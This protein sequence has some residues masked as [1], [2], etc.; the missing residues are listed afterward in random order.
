ML[1]SGYLHDAFLK[2]RN[3]KIF[4]PVSARLF[5]LSLR[6]GS[7]SCRFLLAVLLAKS[8]T[9][10]EFGLYSLIAAAVVY[11]VYVV[12][13]DFYT[14]N[15]R[16]LIGRPVSTWRALLRDQCLLYGLTFTIVAC[17]VFLFCFRG[18]IAWETA[19]WL[20][21]LLA[22]EHFAQELNRLLIISG[23][24]LQSSIELFIRS[25]I[26]VLALF[27]DL[28][29]ESA[30]SLRLSQV[31]TLWLIGC[32]FAIA[33]SL[34][35]LRPVLCDRSSAG[36][37]INWYR[38]R[39][40][41]MVS[42]VFLCSTLVLKGA[43]TVDRFLVEYF[44]GLAAVGA[45][46]FYGSLAGAIAALV[47]AAVI[48]HDYPSLIKAWESHDERKFRDLYHAFS[49]RVLLYTMGVAIVV[50]VLIYPLLVFVGKPHLWEAWPLSAP[51]ILSSVILC[52]ASVPHYSL[53]SAREERSILR[54]AVGGSLTFLVI[55]LIAAPSFGG[56]GV[57]WATCAGA[58]AN[59]LC[60]SFLWRKVERN[61]SWVSNDKSGRYI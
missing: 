1:P 22:C 58:L 33:W 20:L 29:I 54:A 24:V 26:W 39:Q 31:L 51:L 60:K 21:M 8:L 45:Y 46:V 36:Q 57:A 18:V 15:V 3:W 13:L 30:S 27:F 5:N 61:K 43:S 12:G 49:R 9:P 6:F 37:P 16:D 14:Y 52:L 28:W 19:L 47:D 2:I 48:A 53:Y 41:L 40:G 42:S 50:A 59:Y 25:A 23:L 7:L 11:L 34:W 4:K 38:I 17:V 10:E 56:A 32:I 35:C 44:L 55:A